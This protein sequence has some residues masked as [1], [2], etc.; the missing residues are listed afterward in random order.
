M[1]FKPTHCGATRQSGYCKTVNLS[2]N[3][4][5][6]SLPVHTLIHSYLNPPSPMTVPT[7]AIL[8]LARSRLLASR[9][10]AR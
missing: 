5:L 10:P 2:K 6:Y 9:R 4:I 3:P 8:L 1:C 7:T